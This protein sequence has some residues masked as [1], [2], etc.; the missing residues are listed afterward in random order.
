MGKSGGG[1]VAML[2]GWTPVSTNWGTPGAGGWGRTLPR[3]IWREGGSAHTL[4][5]DV[6]PPDCERQSVV[7]GWGDPDQSP[8]LDAELSRALCPG[9]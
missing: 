7:L 1:H 8:S 3:G 6:R 9:V 5:L 4:I 2:A